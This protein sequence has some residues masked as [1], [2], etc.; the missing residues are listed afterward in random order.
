MGRKKKEIY[1]SNKLYEFLQSYIT[2]KRLQGEKSCSIYRLRRTED[3]IVVF[4]I[5]LDLLNGYSNHF[6]FIEHDEILDEYKIK[7][8][9][10]FSNHVELFRRFG[11]NN[12][13]ITLIG[14]ENTID[15]LINEV[16]AYEK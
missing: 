15:F 6:I 14:E 16:I 8:N 11:K 10:L 2:M 9:F 4:S 7:L 12:V 5:M 3:K 13:E 1:K